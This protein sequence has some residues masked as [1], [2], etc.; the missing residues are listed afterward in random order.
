MEK[1][2]RHMGISFE[3]NDH[4]RPWLWVGLEDQQKEMGQGP[5]NNIQDKS[6]LCTILLYETR[7]E[8]NKTKETRHKTQVVNDPLG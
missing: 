6:D 2:G 1:D 7:K 5:D 8:K 3:N 4:Y